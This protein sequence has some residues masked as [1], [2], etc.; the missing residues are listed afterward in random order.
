M[1]SIQRLWSSLTNTELE[2]GVA[3]ASEIQKC[4]KNVVKKITPPGPLYFQNPN[5]GPV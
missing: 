5:E 4:N 3:K 2:S 1:L